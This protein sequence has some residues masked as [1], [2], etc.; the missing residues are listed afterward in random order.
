MFSQRLFD[1][2]LLGAA[3]QAQEVENI[4][5]LEGFA[6]QIRL[7][8]RQTVGKVRDGTALPCMQA[9][10]DLHGKDASGPS[11]LNGLR[12]IHFAKVWRLYLVQDSTK[13]KPRHLCSSLLQAH[14]SIA[15]LAVPEVRVASS[16]RTFVGAIH[17]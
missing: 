1:I 9:A 7:L 15:S 10:Y 4:W 16:R 2:A 13:M 17:C 14:V 11:L 8:G 5:I 6:S 3:G 12:Y